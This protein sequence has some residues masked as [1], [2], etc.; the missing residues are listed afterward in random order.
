[1]REHGSDVFLLQGAGGLQCRI[2]RFSGHETGDA[3]AYERILHRVFTQPQVLRGSEQQRAHK[4]HGLI[5]PPRESRYKGKIPRPHSS[6]KAG[7]SNTRM[8]AAFQRPGEGN[9]EGGR[10]RACESNFESCAGSERDSAP[11]RASLSWRALTIAE[12]AAPGVV[13]IKSSA[14]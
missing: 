8:R 10:E 1:M 5:Q 3:A 9:A 13:L 14:R 7:R 2:E 4:R 11:S 12:S 6:P